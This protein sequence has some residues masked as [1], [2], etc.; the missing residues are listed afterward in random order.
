M[1]LLSAYLLLFCAC[2]SGFSFDA[3]AIRRYFQSNTNRL[4]LA[5]YCFG[6]QKNAVPKSDLSLQCKFLTHKLCY[7]FSLF[8]LFVFYAIISLVYRRTDK[9]FLSM[10]RRHMTKVKVS[11]RFYRAFQ[12]AW[13]KKCV[14]YLFAL[15]DWQ[16]TASFISCFKCFSWRFFS[17]W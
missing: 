9:N 7:K 2:F 4:F 10:L 3:Q 6:P 17:K 16:E 13:D 11:R 12:R 5:V 14:K 8:P 1:W 15:R